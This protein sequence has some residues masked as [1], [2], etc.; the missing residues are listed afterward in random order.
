MNLKAIAVL[1]VRTFGTCVFSYGVFNIILF[2][3]FDTWALSIAWSLR[4]YLS[5]VLGG[6]IIFQSRRIAAILTRGLD[7]F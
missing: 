1:Q 5:I 3:L 4:S 2:I 7:E 6:L